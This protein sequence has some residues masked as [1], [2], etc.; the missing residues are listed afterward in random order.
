MSWM[1]A[2]AWPR[3]WNA[4]TTAPARTLARA[5]R[6]PR[7]V[8]PPSA[9]TSSPWN[10]SEPGIESM[11]GLG[12][13]PARGRRFRT[14][15]GTRERSTGSSLAMSASHALPSYSDIPLRTDIPPTYLFVRDRV[16]DVEPRGA[17]RGQDRR[18]HADDDGRC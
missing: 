8:K 17:D 7:S 13:S 12:T 14:T 6:D 15:A 16:Q 2:T 1:V 3:C 4:F 18:H 10:C 11:R 9:F 5:A